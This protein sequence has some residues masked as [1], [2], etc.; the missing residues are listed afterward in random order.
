MTPDVNACR[1]SSRRSIVSVSPAGDRDV[2]VTEEPATG[3]PSS[4]SSALRR[5]GSPMGVTAGSTYACNRK[6]EPTPT[7]MPYW[8]GW[9]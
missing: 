5:M 6:F 7:A 2:T 3:R 4:L 8:I 1:P 9:S